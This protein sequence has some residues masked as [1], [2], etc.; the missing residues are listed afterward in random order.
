MRRRVFVGGCA[1]ALAFLA[2]PSASDGQPR[3]TSLRRIGVLTAFDAG[4]P[5]GQVRLGAF[6]QRLEEL[7]WTETHNLK[8]DY[9]WGA[10][11]V[12]RGRAYASELVALER[13]VHQRTSL[14]GSLGSGGVTPDGTP[15]LR[16]HT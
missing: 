5:E 9:R 13:R 14:S 8:M 10:N 15:V 1:G 2:W 3:S 12:E 7:G 4:D 16:R 11:N 6:R